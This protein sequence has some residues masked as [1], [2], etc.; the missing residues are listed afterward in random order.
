MK[1]VVCSTLCD[2][3]K[4]I[5]L[6]VFVNEQGF[7]QEFDDIDPIARHLVIYDGDRPVAT[8]RLFEE[9]GAAV[10]GRVAVLPDYRQHHLGAAVVQRLEKE[11]KAAGYTRVGL[12]AQCRVQGFYE[13]LGY[14]AV[15]DTYLDEFC[16]HI[17]MEKAL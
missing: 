17:H 14:H 2:D 10:I 1:E 13:K 5:R 12:S 4:S 8:G 16:E 9:N 3:A 6:Q 7:E 15:G 11:A